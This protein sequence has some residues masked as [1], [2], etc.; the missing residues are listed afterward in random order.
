LFVLLFSLSVSYGN[1]GHEFI[2]LSGQGGGQGGL[3]LSAIVLEKETPN[4][5]LP[6][7]TQQTSVQSV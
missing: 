7:R 3:S 5:T 6:A 1:D 4:K 2:D